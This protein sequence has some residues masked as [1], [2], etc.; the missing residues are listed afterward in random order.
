MRRVQTQNMQTENHDLYRENYCIMCIKI[1]QSLM[2]KAQHEQY[3][4]LAFSLLKNPFILFKLVG[5][6]S[7][8]L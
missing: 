7:V 4:H 6:T 3:V 5:Y 2:L 1:Q 8:E